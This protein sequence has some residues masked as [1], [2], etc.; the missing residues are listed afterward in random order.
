MATHDL[1]MSGEELL[2]EL[3]AM[4]LP[5]EGEGAFWRTRELADNLEVSVYQI[6][7][8]L[9]IL[10]D[11]GRLAYGRKQIIRMGGK[12]ASVE[13][14]ALKKKKGKDDGEDQETT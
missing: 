14:Y 12:P 4:L 7:R 3:E 2:V 1:G 9:H 13:A 8:L 6:K 5:K 11:Q 10:D